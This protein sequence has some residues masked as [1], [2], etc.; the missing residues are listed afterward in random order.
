VL[1]TTF[2]FLSIAYAEIVGSLQ[3]EGGSYVIAERSKCPDPTRGFL[4]RSAFSEIGGVHWQIIRL[5]DLF[6]PAT[7]ELDDC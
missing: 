5:A 1:Y 4:I 6:R 2:L 3:V 7:T